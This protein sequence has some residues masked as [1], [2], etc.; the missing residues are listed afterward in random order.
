MPKF[1][2][3][4]KQHHLPMIL[5]QNGELGHIRFTA[6]PA[7]ASPSLLYP[8]PARLAFIFHCLLGEEVMIF[9]PNILHLSNPWFLVRLHFQT[10]SFIFYRGGFWNF[11]IHFLSWPILSFKTNLCLYSLK[12][13]ALKIDTNSSFF[14]LDFFALTVWMFPKAKS[15]FE[16][17]KRMP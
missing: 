7:P 12:M 8:E 16:E 1:Y 2:G 3:Y 6:S 10:M 4:F 9:L 11:K 5:T 13:S 15:D 17:V 14:S